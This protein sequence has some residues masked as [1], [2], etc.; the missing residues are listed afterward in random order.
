MALPQMDSDPTA[1]DRMTS[2]S[3]LTPATSINEACARL[4]ATGEVAAVVVRRGRPV[5]V[6]TAAALARAA[7]ARR[8][9]TP[10][11]TVMDY[12]AV[13]V[14]PEADAHKTVRTFTRAAWDHLE[15]RR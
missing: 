4:R 8:P 2:A 7:T 11:G 5:G 14:D 1:V 13:P 15:R 10:I 9:D 12:V 6:I 3:L